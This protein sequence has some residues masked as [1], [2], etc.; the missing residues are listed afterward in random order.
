VGQGAH[1][2]IDLSSLCTLA[3]ARVQLARLGGAEGKQE[4][5]LAPLPGDRF[6][7]S[8]DPTPCGGWRRI[9]MHMRTELKRHRMRFRV[10]HELGHALFYSR[11][12]D[13]PRRRVYDSPAQEEFCDA[14]SRELLIPQRL[15]ARVRPTP[16]GI[17]KLRAACDVSLELAARAVSS[18][19]PTLR[20]ALWF[21]PPGDEEPA[22]QWASKAAGHGR[23]L[24]DQPPDPSSPGVKWLRRRRQLLLVS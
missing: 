5:M 14:L 7:I 15:A 22:L 18:A 13:R 9:P 6:G 23:Q 20:I 12:T 11:G 3:G 21:S 19:Q 17:L 4:A 10:G 8:V 24:A 16:Q 1:D 2:P